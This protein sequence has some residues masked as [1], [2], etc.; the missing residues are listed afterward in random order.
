[1]R[2]DL[3]TKLKAF[4]LG[5]DDILTVPF[6]QRNSSPDASSSRVG[7]PG[8]FR[9][10]VPTIKFG[11][12]EIDIVNHVVHARSVRIHLSVVEQNLLYLLA[13]RGGRVVTR[14][15]ISTRSGGA[16]FAMC[17]EANIVDRH[18]RRAARQLQNG[19]APIGAS[20][21]RRPCR[22]WAIDSSAVP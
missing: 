13:G 2:G 16:H 12:I 7:R 3:Q 9:P 8:P 22:A 4:D 20:R 6:R 10:I 21:R 18:V 5:V 15:E 1:L 17:R 14:E 19:Y 11:E